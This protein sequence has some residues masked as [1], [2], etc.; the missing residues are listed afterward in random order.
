MYCDEALQVLGIHF[1]ALVIGYLNTDIPVLLNL[2][3]VIMLIWSEKEKKCNLIK[4]VNTFT[5]HWSSMEHFTTY[6]GM[7]SG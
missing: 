1:M 2:N 4:E 6:L 5:N 3:V 7:N